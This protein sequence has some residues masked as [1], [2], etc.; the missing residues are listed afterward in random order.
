MGFS[1][2]CLF[3]SKSYLIGIAVVLYLVLWFV[4][5]TKKDRINE[6]LLKQA[7]KNSNATESNNSINFKLILN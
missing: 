3:N 4:F 2:F 1:I 7:M 5:K 6:Y